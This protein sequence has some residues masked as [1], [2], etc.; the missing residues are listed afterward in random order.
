[1]VVYRG[2][3]LPGRHEG[4]VP[5]DVFAKVQNVLAERSAPTRRDRTHFH[6]L[7]KQLFCGR[8]LKEGRSGKLVYTR[9][10]ASGVA[11]ATSFV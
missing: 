6:Y 2:E 11:T 5:P 3:V 8:C 7:K 1:M 4:I 10:T 9:L